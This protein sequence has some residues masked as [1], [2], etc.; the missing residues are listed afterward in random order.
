VLNISDGTRISNAYDNKG[1]LQN[2]KL[3][4]NGVVY[5]D[6]DYSYD[7]HDRPVSSTLKSMSNGTLGYAYDNFDRLATTTHTMKAT[8]SNDKVRTGNTYLS[9]G[10]NQTGLIASL[11][12]DRMNGANVVGTYG[13]DSYSYDANGNILTVTNKDNEVISYSYDG[14]DQLTREDNEVLGKSFTYSYDVGGNI[15]NKTGYA[16]TTGALGAA[17]DTVPYSYTDA[18]WKDKLT[19]FDG[20]AI[21]Y[22]QNG[23]GGNPLSYDGYSYTWQ[24]GRQL[25]G[26]SGNG[27]NVSYKYGP[28]GLRT[29]KVSGGTTTEYT[30]VGG[31]LAQQT[32]GANTLTFA[33]IGFKL[34]NA[35]Y[36]YLRNLQG[37]VVGIYDDAGAVVCRY[38]YDAWGAVVSVQD[39]N[40]NE[41]VDPDHVGHLNPLRY[42]GYYYDSENEFVYVTP[43]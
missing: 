7:A 17:V 20:K 36:Y 28:D 40:G 31:Q 29:K 41:I 24:K 35:D 8:S 26:I 38:V 2:N 6:T 39:A 22:D 43:L 5:A 14:L 23:G 11:R 9:S 13:D 18:N 15:L 16:Y 4:K 10:G 27:L 21:T 33:G 1:R 37:D 25:A 42:R 3:A 34:N 32:D 30:Y 12:I 19:A